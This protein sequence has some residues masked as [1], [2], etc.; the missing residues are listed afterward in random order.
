MGKDSSFFVPICALNILIGC[1]MQ[2]KCLK[3]GCIATKKPNG[4][5]QFVLQK[6]SNNPENNFL[7]GQD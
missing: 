1:E 4:T 6:T 3:H 7:L 5:K 2:W